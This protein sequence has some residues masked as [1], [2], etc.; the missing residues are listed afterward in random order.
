MQSL[1]TN[2]TKRKFGINPAYYQIPATVVFAFILGWVG[3]KLVAHL[4]YAYSYSVTIPG[5]LFSEL[6]W[7]TGWKSLQDSG[8]PTMTIIIEGLIVFAIIGILWFIT[9]RGAKRAEER[10]KARDDKLDE[11]PQRIAEALLP[12]LGELLGKQLICPNGCN[13]KQEGSKFCGQCGS[14][15]IWR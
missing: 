10:E 7:D 5:H 9:S 6:N 3:E 13:I 12:A 14:R 2:K 11:L 4:L 1:K 15:L 8:V